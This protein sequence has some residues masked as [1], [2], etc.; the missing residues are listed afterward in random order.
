MSQA[1]LPLALGPTYQVMLHNRVDRRSTLVFAIS[2]A[3]ILSLSNTF[4]KHGIDA[5]FVY[6]ETKPAERQE[7]YEGFRRGD[8]KV[9]VNCG[10]LTEG[11]TIHLFFSLRPREVTVLI[12]LLWNGSGLPCDRLYPS[13]APYSIANSLLAD[14]RSRT[15]TLTRDGKERLSGYRSRRKWWIGWRRSLY[16]DVIR[17]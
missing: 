5:K 2:I 11:G 7:I 13:P 6:Q 8:F 16:S 17:C 1:S 3:H 14:A 15:S 12:P 4:R 9:L 10:I